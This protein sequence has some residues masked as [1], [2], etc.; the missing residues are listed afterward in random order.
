[1]EASKP[2]PTPHNMQIPRI[3]LQTSPQP[4]PDYLRKIICAKAP[5]WNYCHFTDADI[6]AFFAQH[7]S[8]EFPKLRE[9][10]ASFERGGT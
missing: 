1:M 8:A 2:N 7:P 5:G 4:A 9:V 6:L 10:F 3:L